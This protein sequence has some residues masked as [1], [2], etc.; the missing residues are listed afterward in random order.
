MQIPSQQAAEAGGTSSSTPRSYTACHWGIYEVQPDDAQGVRLTAFAR[1]PSP[2]PIGLSM[3]QA[4]TGP[5]RVRQ[6]AVRQ[7]WLDAARG[8]SADS[9]RD[10]R[11]QEPFVEVG[12]DEA[13]D[14][15][16]AEL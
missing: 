3:P 9:R 6:P 7:S 5:L 15:V 13:L 2:S 1:D 16:A 14:L 8:R 11:G 10:L 4:V 12:W